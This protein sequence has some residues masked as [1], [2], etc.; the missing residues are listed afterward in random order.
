MCREL[1]ESKDFRVRDFV[2]TNVR[3]GLVE[4]TRRESNLCIKL[5]KG[6]FEAAN[7]LQATLNIPMTITPSSSEHSPELKSF[8][9]AG[10]R[11]L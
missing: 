9:R 8:T 5:N 7:A 2:K 10:F 1:L 3:R 11:I 6:I 4:L